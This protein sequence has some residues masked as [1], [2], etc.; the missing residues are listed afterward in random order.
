MWHKFRTLLRLYKYDITNVTKNL[1]DYLGFKYEITN[2]TKFSTKYEIKMW[3]KK[4]PIHHKKSNLTNEK[5]RS[6]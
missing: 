4:K 2:V 6:T 1:T 5:I 3:L